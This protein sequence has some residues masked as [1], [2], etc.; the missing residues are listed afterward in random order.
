[1]EGHNHNSYRSFSG[2]P[3]GLTNEVT[4]QPH[5]P[6]QRHITQNT[7]TGGILSNDPKNTENPAS[8]VLDSRTGFDPVGFH[9]KKELF[10]LKKPL[11]QTLPILKITQRRLPGIGSKG[12]ELFS[13]MDILFFHIIFATTL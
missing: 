6:L 4:S 1:M 11:M 2:I 8:P 9:I 13:Y 5:H 10:Y 3:I 7:P 12:C